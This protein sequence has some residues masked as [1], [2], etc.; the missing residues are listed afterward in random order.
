M[1]SAD[2]VV[3]LTDAWCIR[4]PSLIVI[5]GP[6]FSGKSVWTK[7]L[8]RYRNEL[9]CPSPDRIVFVHGEDQPEYFRELR[10]LAP[11]IQFIKGLTQAEEMLELDSRVKNLVIIDD[12]FHEALSSK[13][14]LDLSTKS[15]HHKNTSV[16]FIV[17]NIF[18]QSKFSKTISNQAKYIV[19][20]KNVRD[21]NQT[22]YIGQQVLGNGGGA[23]L[24]QVLQEVTN[25]NKFG[26]IVLD[27]HP[28]SNDRLRILTGIF[29]HESLYPIAFEIVN[30]SS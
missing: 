3:S 12:L 16:V 24:N 30:K 15:S 10:M 18:M 26:S 23:L 27:L 8:L 29:P 14:F 4:H 9:I 21:I 28:L 17:Q 13:W 7:N 2:E 20:F 25:D 6:T 5:S 11:G 22:K 1:A 19:I